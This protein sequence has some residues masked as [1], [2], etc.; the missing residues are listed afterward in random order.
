MVERTNFIPIDKGFLDL[1]NI[2]FNKSNWRDDSVPDD[3]IDRQQ[4]NFKV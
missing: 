2:N 1:P 4:L 3:Q